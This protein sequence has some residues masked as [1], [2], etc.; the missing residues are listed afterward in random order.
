MAVQDELD[1]K[2]ACEAIYNKKDEDASEILFAILSRHNLTKLKQNLKKGSSNMEKEAQSTSRQKNDWVKGER[3]KWNRCVDGYNDGTPWRISRDQFYDFTHY[4]TDAV[5][6]DAD[7]SRVYSG[8]AIWRMYVMDKFYREYKT[9]EGKWV[10]G[11]INDRFHVFP[12]AGTPANPDAPRD[13]GNQMELGLAE[14]TRKPRPHQYSTE[15]RMEEARGNKTY[16][17]EVTTTAA[18]F[19]KV[20]KTASK[21]PVSRNEDMIY[22]MFT[23]C[24]EM[25]EAGIDYSDMLNKVSE[26]YNTSITSVAEIS[27]FADQMVAKHKG[28]AYS[29]DLESNTVKAEHSEACNRTYKTLSDLADISVVSDDGSDMKVSVLKGTTLVEIGDMKFEIASG[30]DTGTVVSVDLTPDKMERFDDDLQIDAHECGLNEPFEQAM[31]FQI[32]DLT[33]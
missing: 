17:L 9:A 2:E 25:K 27:Q 30:K 13:G 33:V 15:R 1:I 14:R 31:P 32:T 21:V 26:H 7:P 24:I 8:E 4:Y 28:I 6:F 22:N 18:N 11:Y 10:G 23:D 19:S 5:S 3:N 20:I 16:D 12:T 29:F